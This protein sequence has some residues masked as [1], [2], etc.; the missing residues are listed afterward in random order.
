MLRLLQAWPSQ[1]DLARASR[2]DLIEFARG[3]RHGWPERFADSIAA[4]LA[5]PALP[6]QAAM[7]RA[8]TAGIRL[9]AAQ[10]LA[11]QLARREWEQRMGELLVGAST[12]HG[13]RRARTSPAAAKD[14]PQ[15]L[16]SEPDT[17]GASAPASQPALE[18][19][20]EIF[21]G[22]SIYVSFP[23]LG[24]RLAGRIA[25]EIGEDI[26]TFASPN[27]LQ[28]YAGTAPVTRRSGKRDHVVAKRRAY[29]HYLGDA[30]HQWAFCS[31]SR[32]AWAR[33][34][35]DS[36]IAAGM[37][38]HAALRALSN[39]WLEVLWHCLARGVL[40]DEAAH[41]ANRQRGAGRAA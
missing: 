3:C 33:E 20:P 6:V 14:A 13:R 5:R 31:L 41:Q 35:Y 40:Y 27:A 9:A 16:R 38:C 2:K 11:L 28:C 30:V 26:R 17:A 7:V 32:S 25:G 15:T 24:D 21:P 37:S 34:F 29:N 19:P 39:R 8:K 23:G 1:N 22:G 4:A 36:K 18:P 12:S 10:L